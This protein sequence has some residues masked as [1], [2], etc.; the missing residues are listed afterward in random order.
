MDLKYFDDVELVFLLWSFKIVPSSKCSQKTKTNLATWGHHGA[1]VILVF[2]ENME[3]P[4]NWKVIH[5]FW[6][7]LAIKKNCFCEYM[8][9]PTNSKLIKYIWLYFAFKKSCNFCACSEVM[10][11]QG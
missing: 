5:Y 8:K 11:L 9:D 3:D 1:R 7:V 6:L 4:T 10:Q 2:C